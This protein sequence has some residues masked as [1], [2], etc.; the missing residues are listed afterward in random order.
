M[1]GKSKKQTVGYKYYLGRHDVLCHGPIDAITRIRVDERDAWTG[2]NTGG[3]LTINAENI[4]GG[5]SREGGVSGTVD[6]AMGGPAQGQNSYLVSKLG[7]SVPAY[8]G[9]VSAI[10]RQVY[11]GNNPYL[12]NWD[13]RGTRI[14]K[15]TD[16]GTQWYD[17]KAAIVPAVAS[18]SGQLWRYLVV[19]NSDNVN[20]SAISFNDSGWSI[21]SAPFANAPWSFP[22]TYGFSGTPATVVPS[23]Q[24]V[25]MRTK[26]VLG[27]VP[28]ILRFEA[29]VDN[30]CIIYVN[31]VQA[32]Q[33]GGNNGAYY[34]LYLDSSLF[35]VGE[36]TIAVVGWDRHVGS[37]PSNWFWFDWRLTDLTVIDM[38]PAHIIRECLTDPDWG[39]GY[40]AADVDDTS[41]TAAADQL[42]TEGLGISLL[43][44]RQIS[45]ED[46]I[47]EIVKHIDGALYVDRK[48]GKFVLKL[49][50]DDYDPDALIVLDESNISKITNPA[51]A[52][53]G[54]LYNS[55]SVNFWNS[56]TGK[57]DSITVTD[58]ALVQQQ[59]VVINTTVQYPGFT[60]ARNATIAGQ[61]DLRVLSSPFL[62]CTIYTDSTAK[63]LNIGDTF[64]L[65]WGRWNIQEMVMRVTGIA[66]GDGKTTQVR[67]TCTQDV[68]STPLVSVVSPGG[69]TEWVDPSAPPA[70]SEHQLAFEAPYYELVQ[71]LGQSDIDASLASKSDIGYVMAA[72]SRNGSPINARMWTDDGTGYQD[73]SGLD[74]CP[75]ALLGSNILKTTTVLPITDDV[76]LDQVTIGTHCQIGDELMRVDAVDT[77]GGTITV[78]RGVLDTVP[79]Y[80]SAGDPIFFWDLFSGYDPTEYVEGEELGVKVQPVS[81]S[82][83]VDLDTITAD[84]VTIAGRAF[85][86]YPP[87][88]LQIEAQAYPEDV[89]LEGELTLSWAHRDRVQQTSGTLSDHTAGDIGPEAG[90][91]YRLQGYIDG[92]LDHTEDDIATTSTTWTPATSG[93]LVR[94]EVHSKRDGIYSLQGAWHEFYYSSSDLRSTVDND[95]RA[96]EEGDL[97]ATED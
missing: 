55:V 97:R 4:F 12:K 68:Y 90:T 36:N 28:A 57:D 54:E 60:N 61:R 88:N 40:L 24:K 53:F 5:E 65:S 47:A 77:V 67:I 74:F 78:G 6:I 56:Q 50:R 44:D 33:V 85:R 80:H 2:N 30:D 46:F 51:R 13:Y 66:F 84:T 83:V 38:N 59:G 62:S 95:I 49:I 26:L 63:D 79:D 93:A 48:T 70:A 27:E 81:G 14:H 1:G 34:D 15:T 25:W 35:V 20:R 64:K 91:T 58:P 11:H 7:S 75:L 42:F 32:A 9:V 41:F 10:Y 71:A 22:P 89:I 43:W 39:M 37:P 8:R 23:G 82:G 16:G 96:T 52:T 86:P 92:V 29:F 87:G 45:I 72:A 3:S 19:S 94:V 73:T 76:D 21:G 18:G 17:A 69:G 31:G